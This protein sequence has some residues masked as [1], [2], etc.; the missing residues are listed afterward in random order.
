MTD[1]ITRFAAILSCVFAYL[2]SQN[3][4]EAHK[5]THE[6]AC[7]VGSADLCKWHEVRK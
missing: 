3:S 5:H 2:A 6:L 4:R 7:A 1:H